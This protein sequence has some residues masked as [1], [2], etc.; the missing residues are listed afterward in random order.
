[1]VEI[2][3]I[4]HT[5]YMLK[6]TQKIEYIILHYAAS[7][8]SS[9][10]SAMSIKKA[11]DNSGYSSDYIVDD[12]N[13]IQ[14]ADDVT[15]WR[16]KAV[17]G[18]NSPERQKGTPAGKNAFN[19]NSISIEMASELDGEYKKDWVANSSKFKFSEQ[20]LKNTADLCKYLIEKYNIPKDH[21]I[22]HYDVSGKACPGIIGWNL[23]HGSNSEKKYKD[24][25]DSLYEDR[26]PSEVAEPDYFYANVDTSKS[27]E[28]ENDQDNLP[29][30]SNS[31]LQLA[32]VN[33]MNSKNVLK[34][35]DSRKAKFEALRNELAEE[36]P[37]M[38]RE[39]LLT[40]ELYDSNI[41]K[42]TQESREERN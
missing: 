28:Q 41:L 16:S 6:R 4:N 20:V 34:Q 38:G 21:I 30:F 2:N 31:V 33:R 10:G 36:A 40:A 15:K 3:V 5:K 27:N 24:F 25:V 18:V 9:D 12:C 42:G 32:S 1:M 8:K 13:I 19:Q 17:Q 37:E 26:I 11:L 22:R 29:R 23:A 39:I 14:L 35:S 7:L